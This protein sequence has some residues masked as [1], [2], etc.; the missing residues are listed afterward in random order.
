MPRVTWPLLYDRPIVRV[1]LRP[2][3]GSGKTTGRRGD[4]RDGKSREGAMADG[5]CW[6]EPIAERYQ[7]TCHV[8]TCQ[9]LR[10][11]AS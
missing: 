10:T 6:C 11:P 8:T 3:G 1:V 2:V 9:L 4:K 5:G 7:A